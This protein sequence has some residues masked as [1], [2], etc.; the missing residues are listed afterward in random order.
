M[1][2]V[3]GHP[4]TM[5]SLAAHGSAPQLRN[6]NFLSVWGGAMRCQERRL[7]AGG[8]MAQPLP[9]NYFLAVTVT[10]ICAPPASA[11]TP[12]VVRV[13]LGSGMFLMYTAFIRWNNV[14][15]VK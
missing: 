8:R 12:T 14:I 6:N 15:S 1:R 3:T 7:R 10:S 4:A 11:V 13:G 2:P 9:H 5:C